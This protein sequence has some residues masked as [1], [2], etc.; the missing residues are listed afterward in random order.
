MRNLPGPLLLA[1]VLAGVEG[2]FF[3]GYA[4][5]EVALTSTDR[6]LMAGTTALFFAAYGA[7]LV[8]CAW[9]VTDRRAWARS[10]ILL[11]QL[12]QL[13]I[14][15]QFLGGGTT[16]VAVVLAVLAVVGIGGLLAPASTATLTGGESRQER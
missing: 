14:A 9:G 5:L 16:V 1:A 11:A 10:P 6:L 13:A 15:W 8:V 4:A 12:I 2:V 7:G 3:L